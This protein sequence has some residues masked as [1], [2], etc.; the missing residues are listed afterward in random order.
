MPCTAPCKSGA[1][2]ATQ[3]RP[4]KCEIRRSAI[5]RSEAGLLH[6]QG[7]FDVLARD[8]STAQGEESGSHTVSV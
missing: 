7:I 8:K 2:G 4:A 5:L 1:K 3:A 6:S